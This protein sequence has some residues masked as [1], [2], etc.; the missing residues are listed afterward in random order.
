MRHTVVIDDELLAETTNAL[1][2]G[3]IRETIETALREALQKRK[4]RKL[5]ALLGTVDMDVTDEELEHWR[6]DD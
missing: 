5:R 1:G 3:T 2:T 4:L 6:A